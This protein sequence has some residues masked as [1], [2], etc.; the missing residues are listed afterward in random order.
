M[1]SPMA[2]YWKTIVAGVVAGMGC[3]QAGTI[4][5]PNSSFES[6][7]SIFVDI[8]IDAW[9]KGAK[10]AWFDESGG[11]AWNQLTGIF[12]NPG[13]TSSD[14]LDNCDGNQAIW[15]F[16]IPEVELFQDYNSVD[17]NDPAPTHAFDARFESGKSYAL[18]VA[19]NGGGG[20][21]SNGATMQICLYYR[22][23]ASNKVTVAST[24][25]TNTPD[26]FPNHTHLVDFEARVPTVRAGEAH[27]GRNIGVQLLST[28]PPQ[29]QG[30]Y[31]DLDN[32]RLTSVQEPRVTG[33][34]LAGGQFQ[35]AIESDPGLV[36]EIL[37]TT[38]VS[39]P[40]SNW[41][42]LGTVTN[43]AGVAPF[44]ETQVP[45]GRRFYQARQVP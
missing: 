37:A 23:A 2:R 38:N 33:T 35:F 25:V 36:F 28:V 11:F 44:S 34:Q 9:Q 39:L 8:N 13:P 3:L 41:V 40:A 32:V 5:I 31:W 18:S 29:L 10:P 43:T 1:M 7:V 19:V 21:M 16:A 20:G 24:W 42:R 6:P 26:M 22:D 30:G 4:S 17:W 14:H 15:M 12:K 27:A 45:F